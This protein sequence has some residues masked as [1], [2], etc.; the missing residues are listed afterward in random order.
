MKRPLLPAILRGALPV[1]GQGDAVLPS[2]HPGTETTGELLWCTFMRCTS[3][4][5]V[6]W[7]GV[8]LGCKGNVPSPRPHS[9]LDALVSF[10]FPLAMWGSEAE[11]TLKCELDARG[12][13]NRR[14][15][16][17]GT[18]YGHGELLG[19]PMPGSPQLQVSTGAFLSASETE[20]PGQGGAT[21]TGT[22]SVQ[23]MANVCF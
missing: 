5:V 9:V 16:P 20:S 1:L 14:L 7:C 8:F 21:G 11:G 6:F 10:N 4:Y 19:D 2:A 3:R 23:E 22:A 18:M 17:S 15:T 12:D 13:R